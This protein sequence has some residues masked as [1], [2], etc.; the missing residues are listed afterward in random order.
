MAEAPALKEEPAAKQAKKAHNTNTEENLQ[1]LGDVY[2]YKSNIFKME[3]KEMLTEVRINYKKRMAPAE[4][5]L[6]L[7]KGVIDNIPQREGVTVRR[8]T[9]ILCAQLR[10]ICAG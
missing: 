2:Q 4:R 10:I 5:I 3:M 8:L 7:L 1:A 6:H 9:Q